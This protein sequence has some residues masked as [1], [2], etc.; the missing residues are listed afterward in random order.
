MC[1]WENSEFAECPSFVQAEDNKFLLAASVCPYDETRYFSLMYGCF[2]NGKFT[3]EHSAKSDKGP[4]Q[5]AGQVFRD[6]KGRNLLITWIPGW[7]CENTSDK[8]IGC[9]SVPRELTYK[10]GKVFAYPPRELRHLLKEDDPCIVRTQTGFIIPRSDRE[11]LIHEGE[12]KNLAVLR[13][14]YIAEVFVN[15]GESVYSVLL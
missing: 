10:D 15:G 2:E 1:Q 11:P 12:I 14:G 5:Y 7:G 8:N 6:H 9:L 13:D 4:D 3:I